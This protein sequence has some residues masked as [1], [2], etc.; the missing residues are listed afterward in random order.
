MLLDERREHFKVKCKL[1]TPFP[2]H[3]RGEE[4]ADFFIN[5]VKYKISLKTLEALQ[6]HHGVSLETIIEMMVF[7][8]LK[9]TPFILGYDE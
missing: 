8:P 1:L 6:K 3:D 2:K 4:Y 9:D 7:M 5:D